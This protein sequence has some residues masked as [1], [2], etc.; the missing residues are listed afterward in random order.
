M[1]G[2]AIAPVQTVKSKAIALYPNFPLPKQQKQRH[3]IINICP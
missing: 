3:G 1:L 2:R